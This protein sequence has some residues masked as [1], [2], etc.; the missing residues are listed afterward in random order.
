MKTRFSVLLP[1]P[2][3][4]NVLTVAATV[5]VLLVLAVSCR[6][7][8]A[9]LYNEGQIYGTVYHIVYESPG[10]K[11][12][13]PD[14]EK[15]L[16]EL[17]N[18]FSTFKTESVISKVNT[19]QPVEL[20]PLFVNCFN[21]SQEISKISGGAFDITVAPLVN[22]WGF[23]F[24]HK[25]KIT[26]S[27]I[28]SLLS[29]TGYQKVKIENGKIIKENPGIMLD[30]SAI[31]KGYTC[32][33]IGELLAQ[34]GCKNYMVEIGGEVVAR[35][36]NKKGNAWSIGINKP[37]ETAF[38]SDKD[39]QAVVKLPERAL[40]TSGNYRN[41]YVENGKKFAHTID[42]KTGYPVQHSLLS[43]TVLADNCMTADAFATAFMV[44]GLEKS[45]E[46][47]RQIP[48]IEVYFIY[49]DETGFNKVYMSDKFREHLVE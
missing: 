35:G 44:M 20:D 11:E 21:R 27:L 3:S 29:L 17:D 1:S 38:Y 28:D 40:A 19:N 8:D 48:E 43:A 25:E 49:S 36:V 30:M 45:V 16:N 47:S 34:K 42:P 15:R 7:P 9:Y 37:D 41:F 18:I 12:L 24:K 31:A 5:L 2:F 6:K 33:L 10:G 14:I 26:Q 46:L 22:A 4:K 13:K 32:D 23:G 39:L